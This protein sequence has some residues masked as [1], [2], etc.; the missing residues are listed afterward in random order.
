MPSQTSTSR[1]PTGASLRIEN[2]SVGYGNLPVLERFS[3][4]VPAGRVLAL[5]GP[6][7][8]GKSTLAR[9][10]SGLLKISAG[11]ILL[12]GASIARRNPSHIAASGVLHVPET[13]D[14]FGDMT[15]WEN[16]MVAFDNLGQGA[17]EQ[18]AFDRV[19]RL[20]PLLLER[21]NQLAGN[22]SGGQQQM[23]AIG[24]A[25][26]GNPRV[27]VLDEPSLGLA[28]IIILEIYKTLDLL[29]KN[30][31][32]ILLIEQ[33]ATTAIAFADSTAVLVG[34]KIVMQGSRAEMSNNADVIRHYLGTAATAA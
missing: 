7:G 24:R 3:L 4:N 25:L 33:A 17:D 18:A 10:V 1:T 11:D 23:L 6:N 9:A 31:L 22:L 32:T 26:L 19:Y 12:D 2:L 30:G 5:I 28:R 21:R 14:I 15:V 29:R 34:G 8:A 16:L 20:F 27:L 13:R